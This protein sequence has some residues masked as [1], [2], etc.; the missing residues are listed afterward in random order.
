MESENRY[1]IEARRL[2]KTY[3]LGE[4]TITALSGIDMAVEPG[5]FVSVMGP[6]GSGK[7]TLLHLLGLLDVPDEG[8]VYVGGVAT[9]GLDD[10]ELTRLR[11]E[12]LG[13]VFQ[14]FELI[15]NLDARE[16]ILLPAEVAGRRSAG[17]ARLREL[18]DALG[19]ADRLGHRPKQLSGGQRQRVSLARALIN[20]PV[21]VLADEPTGNLDSETGQEVLNL[22][23][24]G[25]D[26]R[27]WTVVMVTHDPKAAL[28]ADTILFLRDGRLSGAVGTRDPHAR[29]VIETFVGV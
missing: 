26:D 6:S 5:S 1:A 7:S 15:P 25:V 22:L 12:R 27:G 13:F 24:A 28:N 10:D 14:T 18:A 9:K 29:S 3:R 20:D 16:N 11:R 23:R 19:I 21:V 2:G 4:Q 17:E 8:E